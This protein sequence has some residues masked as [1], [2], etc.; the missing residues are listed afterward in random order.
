[1]QAV[2]GAIRMSA[3]T[4]RKGLAELAA[5]EGDPDEPLGARLRRE[6]GGRRRC[7]EADRQ[8]IETLERPAQPVR[9]ASLGYDA[10]TLALSGS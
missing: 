8:L 9:L 3:N 5:R 10:V 1:L 7:R 4:I 6:G 2:S